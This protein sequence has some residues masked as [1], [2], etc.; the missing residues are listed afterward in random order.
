MTRTNQKGLSE[1]MAYIS[2]CRWRG[3]KPSNGWASM[4]KRKENALAMFGKQEASSLDGERT[5]N[6]RN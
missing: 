2:K 5:R 1:E 4:S 6:R 3:M